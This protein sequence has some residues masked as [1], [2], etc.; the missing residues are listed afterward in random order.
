MIVRCCNGEL[1]LGKGTFGMCPLKKDLFF[2][3]DGGKNPAGKTKL[4]PG[5]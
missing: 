2:F 4:F 5:C 3:F 1:F